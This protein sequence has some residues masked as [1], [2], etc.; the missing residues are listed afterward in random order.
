MSHTLSLPSVWSVD[1]TKLTP[2][3]RHHDGLTSGRGGGGG[4]LEDKY[5]HKQR[6]A[7]GQ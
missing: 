4:G 2:L 7:L 6:H 3:K 1:G 5:T